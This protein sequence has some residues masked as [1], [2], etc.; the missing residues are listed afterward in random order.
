MEEQQAG[1]SPAPFVPESGQQITP[2]WLTAVLQNAGHDVDVDRITVADIGEGA[3]MLGSILRV[4]IAYARGGGEAP[5]SVVVKLPTPVEQN[6]QVAVAF[7]NYERE[8]RFYQNAVGL[9][10]MRTPRVYRADIIG[11]DRFVLVL[12]D[13]SGWSRGDQIQGCSRT[14]ARHCVAAL[15][16]L[17]GSFWNR[18][19]GGDLDWVP[20]SYRSVMSEGL[21]QGAEA[22]YVPFLEIFDDVVPES[23]K[24]IKTRYVEALPA[25][26]RW[27]NAPPRTLI[28]GD[29]R[30][31]NL[32]FGTAPDHAPV[33]CCDW[34]A[35]LRGKGIHDVAYLLSGSVPTGDRRAE[36]RALIGRWHQGLIR[37]GVSDYGLDEAWED[38][39]RAVL[40]L[41]TYAVVIGG[42]LDPDNPRGHEWL[43]HMVQRCGAAIEDLNCLDLLDDFTWA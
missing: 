19:D 26:Q 23:L 37:S 4:E 24:L 17:H 10:S 34:Q 9:T 3:G 21:Q 29:F 40:Y 36:E 22:L 5:S 6:R 28:H 2:G 20:D 14:Q 27:I 1:G 33:A 16:E 39:R 31:D 13:L 43:R 8:V 12:E 41:W 30:M 11:R 25:M 35:S 42:G 38:Y 7:N 15:A 32:F 18:V